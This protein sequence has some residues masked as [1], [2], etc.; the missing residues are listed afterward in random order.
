MKLLRASGLSVAA[1]LIAVALIGPGTA[2]ATSLCK[3]TTNPC[4][5]AQKYNAG[6]NIT[7]TASNVAF[8]F[9]TESSEL[10]EQASTVTCASSEL[11]F[12]NNAAQGTPLPVKETKWTFF[13]GCIAPLGTS[14]I[15][16][17]GTNSLGGI[18]WTSGGNGSMTLKLPEISV[19]CTGF[20][21]IHCTY[22]G[23]GKFEVQGT[24][25]E[26]A[27]RLVLT[28]NI[29]LSTVRGEE[30]GKKSKLLSGA[31]Y[32]IGIPKPVYVAK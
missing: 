25:S 11:N 16:T 24:Q 12:T 26:Q 22:G 2:S 9:Y 7:T 6:T 23:E 30:C 4:P 28:E 29:A 10:A 17:G 20:V 31:V 8:R 19:S 15:I 3:V 21:P 1:A 32:T 13:D 14:C 5:E 18:A 27:A